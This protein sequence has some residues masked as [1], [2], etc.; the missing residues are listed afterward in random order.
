MLSLANSE[1][2]AGANFWDARGHVMSGS[3][4]M[5][6]RKQIF[7]WIAAHE[8]IFGAQ[9]QP[10]GETG[11]YF[12]DTTRNYYPKEFVAAYRGVLLMLLAESRAVPDRHGANPGRVS[13][14][15]CWCCRMCAC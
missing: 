11:V 1:L 13:T 15:R 12:S 10:E 4:D 5:P 6:T 8:D 14:A 9:R 2:T 3:N 7:H